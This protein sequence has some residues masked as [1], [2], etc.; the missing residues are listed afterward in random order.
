MEPRV[1]QIDHRVPY[2]VAADKIEPESRPQEFML[3][4][5]PRNRGKSWSCEHCASRERHRLARVCNSCYWANPTGYRHVA[6]LPQ[7][8]A[9]IVWAGE[10]AVRTYDALAKWASKTGTTLRDLILETLSAAA[11]SPTPP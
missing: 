4:C 6:M 5:G 1:L 10:D 9:G 2:G 8:R 7:R 3:L 11:N